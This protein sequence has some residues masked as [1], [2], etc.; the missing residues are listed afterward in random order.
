MLVISIML[1]ISSYT[2]LYTCALADD[3]VCVM[4]KIFVDKILIINFR[5]NDNIIHNFWRKQSNQGKKVYL[6]NWLDEGEWNIE[7]VDL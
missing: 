7:M 4:I 6:K 1:V 2:I 5:D 3:I